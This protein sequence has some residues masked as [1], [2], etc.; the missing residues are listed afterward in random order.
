MN[1]FSAPYE[2]ETWYNSNI[3]AMTRVMDRASDL[4]ESTL[5]ENQIQFLPLIKRIKTLESAKE[6]IKAK[7]KDD[8][9]E[10]TDLIG[11]RVVVLLDHEI[12]KAAIAVRTV[13]DIDE[14]NCI[15][16]RKAARIDSLGYRSLHLV[17][18]LGKRRASLP[19]YK[20]LCDYKFEIQIRTALQHTWAE[21]E[22]K[23]NYKGKFALPT[24]LQR[25]LMVLSGTL[26]LIDSEFSNIAQEA[27]SYNLRIKAADSSLE[28]DTLSFIS[29]INIIRSVVIST[30]PDTEIYLNENGFDDIV[31]ELRRFGIE[32]NAELREFL[33]TK[34]ARQIT[35]HVIEDEKLHAV[36]FLRDVMICEDVEKYFKNSFRE[37]FGFIE[38]KDMDYLNK[39]SGNPHLGRIIQSHGVDI[40][41]IN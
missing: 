41:E 17:A 20:S 18:S 6:K 39:I 4:I 9:Y 38:V 21:I 32:N 3:H 31:D 24:E 37:S 28:N 29:V 13:F 33:Q 23:R 22:H 25:R 27:E 15:D 2:L 10:I 1:R 12:D 40:I 5:Q 14:Q 11:I 30:H 36:G 19:E 7:R 26:E 34:K 35:N 8:A 16:K